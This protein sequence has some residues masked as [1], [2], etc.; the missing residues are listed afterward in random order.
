MPASGQFFIATTT[1]DRTYVV[2]KGQEIVAGPFG[3][4]A[5]AVKARD[6][7]VGKLANSKV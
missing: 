5:E 2:V 6:A 7:L 3:T 1:N 4:A